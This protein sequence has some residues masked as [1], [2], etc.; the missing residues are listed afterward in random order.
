MS[1]IRYTIS[2]LRSNIRFLFWVF[3]SFLVTLFAVHLYHM[4]LVKDQ[5]EIQMSWSTNEEFITKYQNAFYTSHDD[6]FEIT[7]EY[8][9]TV[10]QTFEMF[11]D[12]VIQ[13]GPYSEYLEHWKAM[14]EGILDAKSGSNGHDHQ[15]C[16]G[17]NARL[18]YTVRTTRLQHTYAMDEM[19]E[20]IQ[21]TDL[22]SL[23]FVMLTLALTIYM[24]AYSNYGG[25]EEV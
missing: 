4:K 16:V 10:S 11:K 2:E 23:V 5:H 9:T 18:D 6:E 1:K 25:K 17:L 7:K 8:A 14:L 24:A 20:K 3:F 13:E 22:I 12:P 19:F 15:M 21:L